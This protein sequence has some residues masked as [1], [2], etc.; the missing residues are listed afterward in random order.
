MEETTVELSYV[1][2]VVRADA[3]DA[4]ERKLISIGVRGLTV[5]KAK[6][7][8][9]QANFFSRDSL[10]EE[11][12]LEIV[13]HESKVQE[14]ADANMHGAHTGD[15]GDAIVTELSVPKL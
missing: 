9:K 10:T 4:V 1:I 14:I 8:G 2:A 13:T 6:G 3:L 11:V 5:I 12:K 7:L 15:P